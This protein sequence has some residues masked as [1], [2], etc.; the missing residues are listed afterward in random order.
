MGHGSRGLFGQRRRLVLF[1]VR[2]VPRPGLPV[3]RGRA[4]RDLRPLRLPQLLDRAVERARPDPEGAR[5]RPDQPQGNHGEDVKEYW[6]QLDSTP[7][8]SWMQW[9]Y[10]YPQAEFPY[11]QLRDGNAR[12]GKDERE[13]E[14]ADT[15]VLDEDRFFD[16]KLTYAKAAPDDICIVIEATNH[17][18]EAAPLHLL[19]HVWFRNTWVWGRDDRK[20][21]LR[22]ARPARCS[23]AGHLHAVA[24]EHSFLGRYILAA[25]GAAARPR[26]RERDQ[27]AG[28]V[29]RPRTRPRTPRTASTTGSCTATKSAVN[30]DGRRDEGRVLV[31]VRLGRAGRDGAGAS[32]GSSPTPP[33]EF[34]FGPAFDAVMRRSPRRRRRLLRL[35]DPR[36]RRRRRPG[37]S[38]AAPSPA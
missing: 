32:C 1:P 16:V 33:D 23:A 37:A 3:G 17:G 5:V 6:W 14:L 9:L 2:A 10:R 12:R 4:G 31:F 11:Q 20:P 19:P 13:Y 30:P 26:L 22:P 29:R 28:A 7:T 21:A 25:E 24:C 38:P 18:P 34:T 36:R 27:R 35:G 8:H 15:G